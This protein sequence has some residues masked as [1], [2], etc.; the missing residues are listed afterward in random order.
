MFKVIRPLLCKIA[1]KCSRFGTAF[2]T[3]VKKSGNFCLGR[4][5]T[6]TGHWSRMKKATYFS[7]SI[8]LFAGCYA[9]VLTKTI[10]WENRQ[11]AFTHDAAA[12]KNVT[13]SRQK[14]HDSLQN[15]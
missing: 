2:D 6:K 14:P 4:L 12:R 7:V 1:T 8:L 9:F 5:Q 13:V 11:T 15:Q 10:Q 3:G